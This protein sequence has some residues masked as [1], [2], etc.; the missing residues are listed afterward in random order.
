MV[1]VRWSFL[2]PLASAGESHCAQYQRSWLVTDVSCS[3][4][5]WESMDKNSMWL[6]HPHIL[7]HGDVV[8]CGYVLLFSPSSHLSWW[9]LLSSTC[10]GDVH[11]VSVILAK[12]LPYTLSSLLPEWIGERNSEWAMHLLHLALSHTLSLIAVCCYCLSLPSS[13]SESQ[14]LLHACPN[15]A[16]VNISD[17]VWYWMF[18]LVLMA[19]NEWNITGSK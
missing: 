1:V 8:A 15:D 2:L 3:S 18:S 19:G 10:P 7:Q 6:M 13:V 4:H 11:V 17:V 12:W 14:S 5:Y 9:V 16:C